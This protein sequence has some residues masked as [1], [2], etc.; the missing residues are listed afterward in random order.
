MRLTIDIGGEGRHPHAWNI[1]PR[2]ERTLGPERGRIIGRLILARA[3][4]L[5]FADRS[6]DEVLV[7]RTPLS[8]AALA[9]IARVVKA[10][11]RVLLRHVSLPWGDRH[12]A[13]RQ[14]LPGEVTCSRVRIGRQWVQQTE[15]R[16]DA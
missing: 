11:G 9:E 1:N 8:R 12:E 3:D 14:L 4:A 13:A 2:P 15:F 16:L 6:V 10:D 7:E 5:P